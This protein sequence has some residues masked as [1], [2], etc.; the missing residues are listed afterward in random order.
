MKKEDEGMK[1]RWMKMKCF[2]VKATSYDSVKDK[3]EQLNDKFLTMRETLTK[4]FEGE[5]T[6]LNEKVREYSII[7]LYLEDKV[8][9]LKKMS[10]DSDLAIQ[11]L[12]KIIA[13]KDLALQ[14]HENNEAKVNEK[15]EIKMKKLMSK[16]KSNINKENINKEIINKENIAEVGRQHEKKKKIVK[17]MVKRAD[18][19]K[20]LKKS[21]NEVMVEKQKIV[22][23]RKI[24]QKLVLGDEVNDLN[25]RMTDKDNEIM[26]MVKEK[27]VE[28]ANLKIVLKQKNSEIAKLVGEKQG[29][30]AKQ[31]K[32][33]VLY[34]KKKIVKLV[35]EKE[36]CELKRLLEQFQGVA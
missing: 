33:L 10:T 18:E 20:D 35:K 34:L 24:K 21:L 26:R 25:K 23:K 6:H 2:K 27:E 9:K 11:K 22:L 8:K 5:M 3:F 1:M 12:K 29:G 13:D 4:S 7:V 15:V 28:Q 36:A 17:I 30:E 31:K 32:G 19:A 16:L 14:A